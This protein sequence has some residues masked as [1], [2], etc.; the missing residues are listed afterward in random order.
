MIGG[1]S[2]TV[3]IPALNEEASIARVIDLI[4][5]WVDRVI[6]ADNGS[7]DSTA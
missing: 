2:I 6:V 4:P 3:I 7:T 5:G 1:K